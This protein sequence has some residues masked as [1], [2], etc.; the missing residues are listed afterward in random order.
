[1]LICH[2]Y[3]TEVT[4]HE[5]SNGIGKPF[6]KWNALIFFSTNIHPTAPRQAVLAVLLLNGSYNVIDNMHVQR[7]FIIQAL[8]LKDVLYF[9]SG[10]Y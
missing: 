5:Y 7:K 4:H 8:V 10:R 2:K 6:K 3:N 9:F 1:M